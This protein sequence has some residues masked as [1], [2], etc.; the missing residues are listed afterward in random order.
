MREKPTVEHE[1]GHILSVQEAVTKIAHSLSVNDTEVYEALPDLLRLS[2]ETFSVGHLPAEFRTRE[3]YEECIMVSST[4]KDP[5]GVILKKTEG[6][7]EAETFK[8]YWQRTGE[9]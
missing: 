9:Q 1:K 8:K 2:D 4:G 6:G 7:L 3:D 5:I